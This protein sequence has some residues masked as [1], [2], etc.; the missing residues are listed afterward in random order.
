MLRVICFFFSRL[1]IGHSRLGTVSRHLPSPVLPLHVPRPFFEMPHHDAREARGSIDGI[2]LCELF[3]PSFFLYTSCNLKYLPRPVNPV[4]PPSSF[5]KQTNPLRMKVCG[6]G[7][8]DDP[9][10]RVMAPNGQMSSSTVKTNEVAAEIMAH[11][12]TTLFLA[13]IMVVAYYLWSRR[14]RLDRRVRVCCLF[15][16]IH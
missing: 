13:V 4:S 6:K 8:P 7:V 11:P 9:D 15:S 16:S 14:V 1:L 10:P 3:R 2:A 12:V 5:P